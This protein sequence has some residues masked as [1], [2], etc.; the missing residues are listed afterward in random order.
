MSGHLVVGA[1]GA[2]LPQALPATLPTIFHMR[3]LI[4]NRAALILR[5]RIASHLILLSLVHM[6][7][8]HCRLR[9]VVVHEERQEV[10]NLRSH[11]S[12]QTR[13]MMGEGIIKTYFLYAS[14]LAQIE[15][16]SAVQ[17]Q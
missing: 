4:N 12:A 3:R 9:L 7:L 8:R 14:W 2:D 1:S 5:V 17:P 11:S 16:R 13:L 10:P 15:Q 6:N